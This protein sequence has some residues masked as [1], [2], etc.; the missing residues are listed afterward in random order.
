MQIPDE[1]LDTILDALATANRIA[2]ANR[3]AVEQLNY[4]ILL[5]VLLIGGIYLLKRNG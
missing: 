5:A 1:R 3:V 4:T 2:R